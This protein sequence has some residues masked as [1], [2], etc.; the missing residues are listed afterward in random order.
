M[1]IFY[2]PKGDNL[3]LMNIQ[4]IVEQ[5]KNSQIQQRVL[6]IL[7][8]PEDS[9]STIFKILGELEPQRRCSRVSYLSA[10]TSAQQ[11]LKLY[12]KIPR[13]GLA[14]FCGTTEREKICYHFEPH[15][16]IRKSQIN[17]SNQF[18]TKVKSNSFPF[19]FHDDLKEISSI[20]ESQSYFL[21]QLLDLLLSQLIIILLQRFW[22]HHVKFFMNLRS[23]HSIPKK[24]GR[25]LHAG[26]SVVRIPRRRKE[27]M[28]FYTQE[29]YNNINRFFVSK[30]Q[31]WY[32]FLFD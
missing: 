30:H 16:S 12:V 19:N 2:A 15:K 9:I 11:I 17:Y 25:T 10:I 8:C 7:I 3:L 28:R 14:I 22:V 5:L 31:V 18:H 4:R 13:K 21:I 6:S 32:F 1:P 20:R 29:I 23:L 27:M 26:A 24:K